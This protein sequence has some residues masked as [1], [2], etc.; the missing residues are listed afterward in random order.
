[1][2]KFSMQITNIDPATSIGTKTVLY[3]DCQLHGKINIQKLDADQ[4]RLEMNVNFTALR[5]DS[6]Q[7]FSNP[8]RLGG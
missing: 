7:K 3:T 1:M 4:E 2:P 8:E 6:L 5:F